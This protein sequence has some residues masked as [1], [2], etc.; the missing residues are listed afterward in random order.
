MNATNE[1]YKKK[2]K[3]NSITAL[4]LQLATAAS[5]IIL[6]SLM[7]RTYGSEVNGLIASITQFLSYISL[8]ETGIGG[9]VRAA[10]YKP[11]ANGDMDKV[12]GVVRSCQR[13]FKRL[14]YIFLAYLFI[15]A[16]VYPTFGQ[17]GNFEFGFVF[18]LTLI[19]GIL[20]FSQYYFSLTYQLLLQADQKIYIVNNLQTAALIINITATVFL[21]RMGIDVLT[22]RMVFV[23]IFLLRPIAINIYV[24]KKYRLNREVPYDDDSIKQRWDGFWH[25]IAYFIHRNT[26]IVILTLFSNFREISVYSIYQSVIVAVQGLIMS[27]SQSV[28]AAFGSIYARGD[29]NE[30]EKLFSGYET[31]TFMVSTFVFSVTAVMIVPFLKVYTAGV[32][33]AD[34]ERPIFAICIVLAEYFYTI[35]LPYSNLAL[36]AGFF[37][38]TRN[39]AFVE[40]I[41]N[42]VLSL[43]LVKPLGITG[44]ALGTAA[45]MAFR[46]FDFVRFLKKNILERG[47]RYFALNTVLSAAGGI[48]IYIAGKEAVKLFTIDNYFMWAVAAAAV[49]VIAIAVV[50]ILNA[51]FN[52]NGLKRALTIFKR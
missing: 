24:R 17:K 36:A 19:S 2:L 12:S 49:S 48:G 13:F 9:V 23:L 15:L 50:F 25:H 1:N 3:L 43:I 11:L 46:T 32:G 16:L 42:I 28:S 44:V 51:A 33:D 18:K 30:L 52:K 22:L 6:P 5:G 7:I 31:F 27:L 37:K 39:G 14:S 4:V 34:Y 29:K 20:T 40:V 8:L 10:L 45:A 41:I 21:I 26:D 38:D 47:Y 35:R